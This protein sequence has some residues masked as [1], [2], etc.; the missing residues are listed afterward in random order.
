M[1]RDETIYS[2][3][4]SDF[5]EIYT[6]PNEFNILPNGYNLYYYKKGNQYAIYISKKEIKLSDLNQSIG[7]I[8]F[9]IDYKDLDITIQFVQSNLPKVGIGHYLIFIIGYIAKHNNTIQI[10]IIYLDDDSDLSRSG[11]SIYEKI[12]CIYK[13]ENS[14]EPEM[15]CNPDVIL[16]K[17]KKFYIKYVN[18]GFFT[19]STLQTK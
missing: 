3:L 16:N 1:S 19:S 10:P 13:E 18:N 4:L 2:G 12:G 8:T 11:V 6:L 17:F 9:V 15:E 14:N 5:K 7:Y